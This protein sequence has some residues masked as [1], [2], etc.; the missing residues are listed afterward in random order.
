MIIF[1]TNAVNLIPADGPAADIVRKLRA[2]GR[3]RAAVPWMVMEE[4]AAHQAQLYPVKHQSAVRVLEK[5][6]EVVPWELESS[7]EPLNTE[8]LLNHWRS[9]YGEIFEVIETS[10]DAARRALSR[11]SMGL[12]PAKPRQ[13]GKN[14]LPGGARDVAIWFSIL[15]F[16]KNNPE[17]QVHFVTNNT[18]DFGDGNTYQYPWTRTCAD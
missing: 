8:R 7:L 6:N 18:T 13:P 17:E 1:D 12:L 14:G 5:L 10:G 4:L 9:T 11:E 3:H 2:S 15:E 16:L